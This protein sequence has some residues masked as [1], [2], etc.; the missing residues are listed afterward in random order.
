[1]SAPSPGLLSPGATRV[2]TRPAGDGDAERGIWDTSPSPMARARSL[3]APRPAS[4]PCC[5]TPTRSPPTRLTATMTRPAMASPF[6]NF[7][8]PS[9][10]PKSCDSRS[11][12]R[13]RRARLRRVDAPARRSASMAICLPG[14]ASSVKRAATSATR[15][16]PLA[17]TRNWTSVRIREDDRADHVVAPHHELAERPD[18]LAGVGLGAARAASSETLSA[19]RKSVV[20][21]S[22]VGNAAHLSGSA[23]RSA[24]T[25]SA[26]RR[27]G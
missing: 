22:S 18:H 2:T 10:A 15:S 11:S 24:A 1:M 3:A 7:I 5:S 21:R 8:A 9:I 25:S 17:T 13:R 20:T 6:T 16:A 23:A 26:P 19:R 4:C 12:A 27:R 14:I